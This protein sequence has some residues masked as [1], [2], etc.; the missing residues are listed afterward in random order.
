MISDS[1]KIRKYEE[2]LHMLQLYA[3]VNLDC[4]KVRDLI[5]NICRWSYSH[6]MGNGENTEEE[7]Q[8][9]IEYAFNRLTDTQ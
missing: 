3:E 6:R 4:D 1:E 8:R 9:L 5:G 2:L 7:Q